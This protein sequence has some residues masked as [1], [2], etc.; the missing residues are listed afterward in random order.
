MDDVQ[1]VPH[2]LSVAVPRPVPQKLLNQ[3]DTNLQRYVSSSVILQADPFKG[4]SGV[5]RSI[6][7][8]GVADIELDTFR[9]TGVQMA[10]R[11]MFGLYFIM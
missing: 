8:E 7:G 10:Q 2:D 1:L 4:Y 3:N 11:H 5:I 9:V 6:N